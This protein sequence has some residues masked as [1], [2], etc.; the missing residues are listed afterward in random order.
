MLPLCH[1]GI[2][3]TVQNECL[4]TQT[5]E[6]RWQP[7]RRMLPICLIRRRRLPGSCYGPRNDRLFDRAA[8]RFRRS[9]STTVHLR[10]RLW[11]CQRSAGNR[12]PR[13]SPCADPTT[14][15]PP[16]PGSPA[17][18]RIF[19][20]PRPRV[21]Q[22]PPSYEAVGWR[23]FL[24]V[25]WRCSEVLRVPMLWVCPRPHAVAIGPW[26]RVTGGM[27]GR[28]LHPVVDW[29]HQAVGTRCMGVSR[30]LRSLDLP[31]RP[32]RPNSCSEG[33]QQSG[34]DW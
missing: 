5:V 32:S 29:D 3:Y 7:C 19:W 33:P 14:M 16:L 30:L 9:W 4:R 1:S 11:R 15:S 12:L 24:P 23:G 25:R 13:W 22:S 6:R 26:L 17:A 21:R 20:I 2:V 28:L 31:W 34:L 18:S 8:S 10:R 27:K